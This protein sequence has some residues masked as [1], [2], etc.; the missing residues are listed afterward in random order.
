VEDLLIR[1]AENLIDRVSGPMKFRLLLQPTMAIIFAIR[2]G[3][4]DA[5][6]GRVPYFWAIFT[7]PTRRK[8]L[9]REGW[10]AVSRFFIIAI[11]MDAIY[12]FMVLRWFY[13]G[14]ALAVA[15]ILA[16]LPYVLIR[17]PVNRIMR[18]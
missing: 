4:K 5:R 17:G 14:E 15:F 18:R 7:R 10:K 1:I 8:E 16:F 9:L 2:D 13:P 3:L 6:K 12:Q 11:I